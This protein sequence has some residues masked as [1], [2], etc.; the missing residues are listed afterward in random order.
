MHKSNKKT[1]PVIEFQ[2]KAAGAPIASHMRDI[3]RAIGED[4]NREGLVRT[5]ER[6]EKALRYLTSGYSADIKQIVGGAL[7]DV[8]YDEVVIVRDI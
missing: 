4:P 6:S 2:S 5:P 7:F 3:L 8:V 1:R